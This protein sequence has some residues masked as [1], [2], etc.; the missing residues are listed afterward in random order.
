MRTNYMKK[1]MRLCL[2][3]AL[4]LFQYSFANTYY[5]STTGNDA[6]GDGSS[7]NPWKTLRYA[8][9]KVAANQGHTIQ[10]GAGTFVESG[11]VEV[12]LGVSILGAG[13][14]VTIFKAASSFYYHPADPGYGTDKFL[15]SLSGFNPADGNQSLKNFTVDGD[16]KQL[17]GGIYVRYRNK[18]VIDQVKVQ[19]T[20]FTGIWLWDVKD[21]QLTNSQLLNCSWGSTGFCAG[22]LNL[23]NVERVEVFQLNVDENT[24]YG[25]KAIG[26]DGYNDIFNLKIHDSHISVTPFGLWNNGSAPNIAIELWMSTLV[27]CEIYN[28]YVDNTI[29]LVNSAVPSTG[30]QTIRVHD[31]ILDMQTRASGAGYGIELTIHDAEIDHNYFLAGNYGIANWDNPMQN[32]NIHHNT[33]YALSSIYP[34]EVVRSQWSGLHNVKLYNN[35]I[36]FIGTNT[37]NVV[38]VYGGSSDNIDIKNNL[39]INSNTGYNYY[40]NQL[41]HTEPG[42]TISSLTVL[43]NSTTNLDPGSLVTSLLNLLNPLVNL[44]T[45]PNPA[46]TKTGNRPAPYYMPTTGSSLINAGVNVGYPFTGSAPDIGAYESGGTSNAAPTVNITSPASNASFTTGSTVTINANATDSDGTISKVEFFQGSTKLGED[47]TS[48]YSFAWTSVPAGNYSLT[49][50]GTDNLGGATTST[51]IAISVSNANVAPTV[52][53]TSPVNNGNFA[54][55]ATITV[56]ATA[57]DSDG[58]I[59]K[60]EFFQ[61]STKLGEDLTSPYSFTWASVPAGNY[62]LTAK[63]TDNLGGMTTSTAIAISVSNANVAPTVSITSPANNGSFATGAT[64]TINATAADSDGTISKVEFFQGST[65]LGEDLTSPYSFTWT[66]VPAGNYSLTAK[67]TDNLGGATTSTAITISVSNANVAPT[68]SI[69][70]PANNGSF[71]TGST[72]TINA[73]A[74]DSDGT[75][76]KVEFFQGSTKLGEDLTSPY[77]FAWTSVPAGNY[78]LTAKATDNLGGVTTST[79]I[80]ISVSNGNIAPTVSITNPANNGSFATGSTITINATAADSDGTISKVE[81]FQGSTKLGED[82]TSPYSFAWTSVPAGNYSLT[83]KATDNLG[84]ATTSTAITISV[85]NGNIAPTVSITNPANNGSFATGSTI[86]INA[87]AAD[88]DGTIS[89]VEF[90]QGSTKLGEDL[91]SA[92]SFAWTS[93]SAGNYSLTVKAT[94]NLGAVTTSTPVAIKVDNLPVVS[95]TSPVN[96]ANFATGST[97]TITATATDT[98]GTISKVEFFQ[99]TT[100]LG[101]ATTSPYSFAWTSIPAGNYSLTAKATDN[102]NGVTIS[103][104]I[105]ITVSTANTAPVVSIVSPVTNASF[106]T[107]SAVTINANATD[108]DG[109]ISKVEF[110]QGSTKLGEDLT[111]PYS[112][113]WSSVPA[114]NYS[115]TAKATDNAGATTISIAIP[116]VVNNPT[117][118]FQLGLFASD[119]VLSGGV[120]LTADPTASTGSYFSMPAGNGTNYYIPPSASATFNFQ[121]AKTDT[122]FVWARVKSATVNNQGYF[123]YDGKGHWSNWLAGI[124]TD[125]TWVKLSDSSTGAITSF[126][127]SQGLNELQMAWNDENVQIDRLLI[128]NDATLVPAEPVIASQIAVFPNPIVDKF[129]IQYTSPVA[130]QAQVSIF[131]QSGGTLVMQTVVMANAGVNNIVL[132]TDNIY[133]GTYILVFTPADGNKATTRI[134]IFR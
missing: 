71:A 123:I 121:L 50:K 4:F 12:P 126:P 100:K 69:T 40:P 54:T 80:T 120:T 109:T 55:G 97:I 14:G 29:S 11:L 60:V 128:T 56:N 38:G 90:F 77:S 65:K 31:N 82:L 57:T 112:F 81:F 111:S 130:Q 5:V 98:D 75:I 25:I 84:G 88:S 119:A 20:N 41:V 22:A 122:Y 76:S 94:D 47:L 17:H 134:V 36:E 104:A 28:T 10:M 108:G 33:F 70:S 79:A 45:L 110:F 6:A 7:G 18:V 78:S 129:T 113:A 92:Y 8:V 44:T 23:G 87:T 132:G 95:L 42:A 27:G 30:T 63:A 61:G 125:W 106:T 103:S 83:T 49:A 3:A 9:T 72:I 107:G 102:L 1:K 116:V 96:N 67:A 52:S 13:I 73:T 24:G 86:T 46:V 115:L 16:S 133:N 68:V 85:S 59:S 53:I 34:G 101:Q 21:S 35:T 19:N 93:V 118:T 66:S 43:N 105:A 2:V 37:M 117:A 131:D 99:G 64:I 74:A 32:W 26:P 91:T 39:V 62:S 89:K 127:F 48:P 15:I 124:H 51:G 114:G 58:T